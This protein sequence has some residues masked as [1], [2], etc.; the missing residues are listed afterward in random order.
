M[1]IISTYIW[2]LNMC[3]AG[4]FLT[5]NV[6]FFSCFN[7]RNRLIEKESGFLHLLVACYRF[8]V[9]DFNLYLLSRYHQISKKKQQVFEIKKENLRMI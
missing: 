8:Y 2:C 6:A 5:S 9:L 3:M 7:Y 4:S 1:K